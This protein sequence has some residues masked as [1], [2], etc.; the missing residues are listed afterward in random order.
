[1]GENSGSIYLYY[2]LITSFLKISPEKY[3]RI[4]NRFLLYN[5]KKK[6]KEGHVNSRLFSLRLGKKSQSTPRILLTF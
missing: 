6:K 2:I 5:L 3:L 1:M 4:V